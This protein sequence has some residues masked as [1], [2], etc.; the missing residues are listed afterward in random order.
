YYC[1]GM[2][3]PE[4]AA[5]VGVRVPEARRIIDAGVAAILRALKEPLDVRRALRAAGMRMVAAP[6]WPFD[7]G[8]GPSTVEPVARLPR[9]VMRVLLADA[10]AGG[11]APSPA[12]APA[13]ERPVRLGRSVSSLLAGALGIV[14]L[15]VLAPAHGA[16]VAGSAVPAPVVAAQAQQRPAVAPLV[17]VREGDS[18]WAI[19]AR[20]LGDPARWGE[21]WRLN[22]GRAFG[23]S[24][25][26]VPG[27]IRPGWMLRLPAG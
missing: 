24:R 17:I 12:A 13:F 11:A 26:T 15:L 7:V 3:V 8:P 2:T 16:K 25:F 19:A 1:V 22:R 18:L 9:P 14:L 6:A 5:V 23:S 27:L 4:V 10:P 20:R 21:I